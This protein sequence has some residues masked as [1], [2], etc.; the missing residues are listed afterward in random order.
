MTERTLKPN[1]ISFKIELIVERG[2]PASF[3]LTHDGNGN[4]TADNHSGRQATIRVVANYPG[5]EVSS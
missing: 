1:E 5:K 4:L 2:Y 3:M